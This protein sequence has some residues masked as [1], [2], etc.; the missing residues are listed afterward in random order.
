MAG[1]NEASRGA[2]RRYP[3]PRPRAAIDDDRLV[4]PS[5]Q[6]RPDWSAFEGGERPVLWLDRNECNDP[7][8]TAVAQSILRDIPARAI[9]TYPDMEPAY[10]RAARHFGVGEDNLLIAAGSEPAIR[11]VFEAFV[12]P[13][14]KVLYTEPTY[15]MGPYFTR[16]YGAQAIGVHHRPSPEG[17]RLPFDELMAAVERERPRLVYL[18]SPNSPTNT[19][20]DPADLNLLIDTVGRQGGVMLAD[21]AYYLFGEHTALPRIHD[22]GHLVVTRTMSKAWGMAGVRL[23]F[24]LACPEVVTLLKRVAPLYE[25]GSISIEMMMGMLD[26]EDEMH[27]SVARLKDGKR[28][29]VEAMGQLGVRAVHGHGCFVLAG[30]GEHEAAVQEA[31]R[32]VAFFRRINHPSMKGF[33]RITTTTRA[34][35]EPVVD[36]IRQAIQKD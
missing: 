30:F 12:E 36:R 4:R 17:P 21:E 18:P 1:K 2:A 16:I 11:A 32:G 31:L 19:A 34:Q 26:R 29:F 22:C 5:S 23:G 10:A 9:A 7:E 27:K 28:Y 3:P 14:D 25:C 33:Y 24:A 6:P 20:L 13:G 15:I 35:F 8:F